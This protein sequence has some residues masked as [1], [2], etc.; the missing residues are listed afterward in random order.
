MKKTN[1]TW[2]AMALLT[3][4]VCLNLNLN[5]AFADRPAREEFRERAATDQP[6][7]QAISSSERDEW[8]VK[9][10]PGVSVWMLDEE[11]TETA[12]AL[13]LDVWNTSVPLNWRVGVEGQHVDLEQD[14]AASLADGVGR[15]PRVTFIRIPFSVEYKHDFDR[16]FTGYFGGGPD[17]NVFANDASEVQVG[18]HLGAR[19]AYNFDE[20][21][22]VS[23][24]GGYMWA[25]LDEG[26]ADVDLNGAYVSP[27]LNYTF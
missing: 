1:L 25:D 22:G 16:N 7:E 18:G 24:D 5:N 11:D 4:A 15:Q 2:T 17:L 19:I 23:L 6:R 20:H 3:G 14:E 8:K 21:W 27:L 12:P 9:L 13:Y 10:S 26:D